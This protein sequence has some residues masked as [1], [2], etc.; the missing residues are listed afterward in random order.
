MNDIDPLGQDGRRPRPSTGL[1]R[2]ASPGIA[3]VALG[4]KTGCR[5][6]CLTVA[7]AGCLPYDTR[8]CHKAIIERDAVPIIPLRKNGRL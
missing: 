3:P 1:A 2:L 5:Q 8:R 6:R 7:Y 4:D